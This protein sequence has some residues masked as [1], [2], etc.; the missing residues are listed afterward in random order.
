MTCPIADPI[1]HAAMS[2]TPAADRGDTSTGPVACLLQSNAGL[3]ALVSSTY[4]ARTPHACITTQEGIVQWDCN[5]STSENGSQI[6]GLFAIQCDSKC[7]QCLE[8][9]PGPILCQKLHIACLI[10]KA[11]TQLAKGFTVTTNIMQ[12]R[13]AAETELKWPWKNIL[14]SV[15]LL[16]N[17]LPCKT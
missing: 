6:D 3:S 7:A 2:R 17:I 4:M 15:N 13:S 1:F 8:R 11:A 14:Q 10:Y 5:C 12:T 16:V 9:A